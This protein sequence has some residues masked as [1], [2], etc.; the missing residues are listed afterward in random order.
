M[1]KKSLVLGAM[2][3]SAISTFANAKT[4]NNLAYS[5]IPDNKTDI[6]NFKVSA[7][8]SSNNVQVKYTEGDLNFLI[9]LLDSNPGNIYVKIAAPN[10]R[11]GYCDIYLAT[12]SSGLSMQNYSCHSNIEGLGIKGFN[13][14]ANHSCRFTIFPND[15]SILRYKEK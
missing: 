6:D 11:N 10:Q 3:L 8:S 12:S 14:N 4:T 13:C 1:L 2:L 7:A 9:N 5:V 15:R